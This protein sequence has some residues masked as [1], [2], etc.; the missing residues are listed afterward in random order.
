ML[1]LLAGHGN[2]RKASTACD[3]PTKIKLLHTAYSLP[4]WARSPLFVGSEHSRPAGHF[5]FGFTPT[6]KYASILGVYRSTVRSGRGLKSRTEEPNARDWWRK[7]RGL[8]VAGLDSGKSLDCGL[9]P[10]VE[11]PLKTTAAPAKSSFSERQPSTSMWVGGLTLYTLAH[12]P[13]Q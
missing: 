4:Q 11:P 12:Q 5:Y 3:D 9:L 7:S 8:R 1:D 6:D 13:N 10:T 2:I